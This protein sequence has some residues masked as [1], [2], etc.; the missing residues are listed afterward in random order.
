M[1]V[2]KKEVLKIRD[3]IKQGINLDKNFKRLSEMLEALKDDENIYFVN[4]FKIIFQT[5]KDSIKEDSTAKGYLPFDHF[6]EMFL[7]SFGNKM[8]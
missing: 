6:S 7:T 5:S 1:A 8:S 3:E 4:I 2:L